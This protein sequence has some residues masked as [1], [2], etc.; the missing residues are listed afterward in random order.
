MT[1][2]QINQYVQALRQRIITA[3]SG[4]GP[5]YS[6]E[7]RAKRHEWESLL[8]WLSEYDLW[9]IHQAL[10]AAS[11][12]HTDGMNWKRMLDNLLS[13][14]TQ[15]E[16]REAK[17]REENQRLQR[18]VKSSQVQCGLDGTTWKTQIRIPSI[19]S[20]SNECPWVTVKQSE[21]GDRSQARA[22]YLGIQAFFSGAPVTASEWRLRFVKSVAGENGTANT[23]EDGE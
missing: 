6:I 5:G 15:A 19:E 23:V 1:Q 10:S 3:I 7:V 18:D 4:R 17:L 9:D 13:Q 2:S 8:S 12:M 21:Y 20:L 22:F 11:G 16:E 14:K